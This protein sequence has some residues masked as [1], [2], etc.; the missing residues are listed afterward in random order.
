MSDTG[1]HDLSSK[2]DQLEK[3]TSDLLFEKDMNFEKLF[4]QYKSYIIASGVVFLFLSI[5]RPNIIKSKRI[6]HNKIELVVDYNKFFIS[7]LI[8]S[9]I[10]SGA[11]YYSECKK[12]L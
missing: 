10:T 4:R 6:I 7:L 1:I 2:I 5:I 11:I 9:S 12:F 3:Q 8:G